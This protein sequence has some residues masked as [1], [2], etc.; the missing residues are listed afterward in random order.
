MNV[1][2][3]ILVLRAYNVK[4]YHTADLNEVQ[5]VGDHSARVALLTIYLAGDT[6]L[7]WSALIHDGAEGEVGDVSSAAKWK[8]PELAKALRQ[9]EEEVLKKVGLTIYL[10]EEDRAILKA[11]DLLELILFGAR[12]Y[13]KGVVEGAAIGKRGINA[14]RSLTLPKEVHDRVE[15]MIRAGLVW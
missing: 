8:Y 14:L 6:R 7:V 12:Q 11:A 13:S 1:E 5:T 3:L 2:Q 9:T 10:T 15:V 4:R